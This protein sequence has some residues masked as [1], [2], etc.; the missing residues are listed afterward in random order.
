MSRSCKC[1]FSRSRAL[2]PSLSHFHSLSLSLARSLISSTTAA[3][4]VGTRRSCVAAARCFWR[5]LAS[6]FPRSRVTSPP[7]VFLF[8]L[9]SFLRLVLL[10][11]LSTP[12]R[13]LPALRPA[14]SR[15]VVA[16]RASPIRIQRDRRARPEY[17]G[18]SDLFA[19][20]LRTPR[21]APREAV[22]LNVEL[23]T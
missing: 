14:L 1:R 13:V 18:I 23:M 19:D 5:I 16:I 9:F 22:A 17:N 12:S 4:R 11:C 10:L 7:P 2:R 8:F 15:G 6:G 20:R 3:E 21:C